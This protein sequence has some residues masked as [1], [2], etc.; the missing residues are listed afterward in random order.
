MAL[1]E[2]G[3]MQGPSHR[4]FKLEGREGEG[5]CPRRPSILPNAEIVY[6][7]ENAALCAKGAAWSPLLPTQE[8]GFGPIQRIFPGK[9]E[10]WICVCVN[11]LY[12][13]MSYLPPGG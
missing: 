7:V 13:R 4:L 1:K 3:E 6:G 11:S 5:T 9:P 12:F 10:I 2:T 8:N